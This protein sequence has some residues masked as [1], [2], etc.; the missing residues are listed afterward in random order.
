MFHTE[1]ILL[2]ISI[3]F[4]QQ[5]RKLLMTILKQYFNDCSDKELPIIKQE[6][7][8]QNKQIIYSPTHADLFIQSP[9]LEHVHFK[10]F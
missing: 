6:S 4:L 5:K 9:V 1:V 7:L 3:Y 2:Y 10:S 8:F